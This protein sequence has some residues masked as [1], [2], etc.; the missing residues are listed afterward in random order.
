VH[1]LVAFAGKAGGLQVLFTDATSGVSTYPAA[2]SLSVDQ[3]DRQGRVVL[4][5]NRAANLPCA[6]TDY[7]TCPVAPAGNRLPF[8]VP[9]GVKVAS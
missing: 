1:H 5:F 7:A 3:P 8:A 4:D 2:R 9:A 6:F